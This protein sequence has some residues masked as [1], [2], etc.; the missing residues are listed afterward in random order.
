I[1]TVTVTQY[2][3]P[4]LLV[5]P[6]R[7]LDV[8]ILLSGFI[9]PLEQGWF[10]HRLHKLTQSLHLPLFCVILSSMRFG[11]SVA[12]FAIMLWSR[13]LP[14]YVVQYRWLINVVLITGAGVDVILV[15]ALCYHLSTWQDGGRRCG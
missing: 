9:G 13:M 15:M 12:L 8:A 10:A 7:S 6:P 1:Y 14:D 11:R 2:G 5:T 3:Q 4:E